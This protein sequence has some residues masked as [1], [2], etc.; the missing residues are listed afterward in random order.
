MGCYEGLD[1]LSQNPAGR[2]KLEAYLKTS[3][4]DALLL[5]LSE[6]PKKKSQSRI[7]GI[8]TLDDFC[9][10]AIFGNLK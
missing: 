9:T 7:S 10:V 4:Y 1:R 2:G 3:N 5:A 8:Y 6:L